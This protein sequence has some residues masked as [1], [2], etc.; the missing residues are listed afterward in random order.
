M[1]RT[2]LLLLGRSTCAC[3]HL[4]LPCGGL[5]CACLLRIASVHVGLDRV[6]W[7]CS[8][9]GH[10]GRLPAAV[11]HELHNRNKPCVELE[12]IHPWLGHLLAC[13]DK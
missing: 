10:A 13:K 1:P 5:H 3:L 4:G 9:V 2:S 12:H 8:L 11:D 6:S 7:W